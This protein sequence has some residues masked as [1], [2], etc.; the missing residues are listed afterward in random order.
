MRRQLPQTQKFHPRG[1]L[2]ALHHLY[3]RFAQPNIHYAGRLSG[4]GFVYA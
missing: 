3:N 1:R 2:K 4:G